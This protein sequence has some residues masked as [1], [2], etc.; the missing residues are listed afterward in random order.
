M[1]CWES[2]TLACVAVQLLRPSLVVN[3]DQIQADRDAS[4]GAVSLTFERFGK[5]INYQ[6][7]GTGRVLLSTNGALKRVKTVADSE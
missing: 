1:G 5:D 2:W 7:C 4:A 6:E 3:W